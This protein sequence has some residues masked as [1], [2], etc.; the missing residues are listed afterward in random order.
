MY[1]NYGFQVL[2]ETVEQHSGIEFGRYLAEAVFEPLGMAA[3]RLT[4]GAAEAGYGGVSTV[5]DL[6][7]FAADLLEPRTVSAADARGGDQRA[8]PRAERRA[9]RVRRSAAQ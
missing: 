8:V 2:A 5:A 3:S 4:G 9:A 1:S 6:A 7:V